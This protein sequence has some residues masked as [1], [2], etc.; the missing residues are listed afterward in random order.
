MDAH[1]EAWKDSRGQGD[2]LVDS[3]GHFDTAGG[4]NR[5]DR[6]SLAP[7]TTSKRLQRV[8]WTSASSVLRG[9][10][11]DNE[12]TLQGFIVATSPFA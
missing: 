6:I 3:V 5:I 9:P 10:E 11:L 1:P 8:W 2:R 12:T 4:C 7:G